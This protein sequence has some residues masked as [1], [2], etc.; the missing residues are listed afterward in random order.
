VI[1]LLG[2][3]AAWAVHNANAR[4]RTWIT[5][6][7]SRCATTPVATVARLDMLQ[8]WPATKESY[9]GRVSKALIPATVS[10]GVGAGSAGR[11][12]AARTRSLWRARQRF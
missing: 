8:C 12:P 6:E 1:A 7:G 10:E 9:L 11:V 5:P 4:S 3:V 2:F